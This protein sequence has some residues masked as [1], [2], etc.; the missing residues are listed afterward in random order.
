MLTVLAVRS[1]ADE[2]PKARAGGLTSRALRR[3]L[4]THGIRCCSSG[5]GCRVDEVGVENVAESENG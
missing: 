4:N 3:Q 5:F 1:Q 2:T